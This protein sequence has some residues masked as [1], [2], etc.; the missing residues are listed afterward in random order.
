M[1]AVRPYVFN[2]REPADGGPFLLLE[3]A[4]EDDGASADVFF[5][6]TPHFAV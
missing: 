5:T 2:Q 6:D 3:P 1:P 4:V